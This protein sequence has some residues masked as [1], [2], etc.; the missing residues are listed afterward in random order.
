MQKTSIHNNDNVTIVAS[1]Y[2]N[3]ERE[4]TLSL[5]LSVK[6]INWSHVISISKE[7]IQVKYEL[8]VELQEAYEARDVNNIANEKIINN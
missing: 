1:N 7:K 5:V 8:H 4:R 2:N 6:L 3:E